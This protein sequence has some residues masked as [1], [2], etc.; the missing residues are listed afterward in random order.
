MADRSGS[1]HVP[2]LKDAA[3]AGLNIK[4]DGFYIDGT[5]G[6]GGHSRLILQQLGPEGRLLAIDRDPQA[7][8]AAAALLSDPRF[9]IEKGELGQLDDIAERHGLRGRV[10]GL[11]LDLGVSS[12]QLDDA[13][14]GFSFQ[15]DGPLDMRMDPTSGQSAADWLATVDERTLRR[16]L[17]EFGEERFAGRIAK[18]IVATRSSAPLTRTAELADLVAASVPQHRERKHPATRTF[19]AIR[20]AINKELE[21]LDAALEAS[22]DLLAPGGRLCAISFHSLEDRRVKRFMRSKSRDAEPYRGMPDIPAEYRAPLRIVGKAVTA[23]DAEI[24][25]NP[26]SRSARL[27]IAERCR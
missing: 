25:A 14:R 3:I 13:H 23:T 21:Q 20:I 5:F 22:V 9:D 19:Q 1:Q 11:L 7:I 12:P 17:K 26:R 15:H 6:R 27:R 2:V 10:D 24:A 16:V 8:N 4:A 18:A